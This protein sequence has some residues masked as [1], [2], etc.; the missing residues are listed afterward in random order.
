MVTSSPVCIHG[1]VTQHTTI[2]KV[3]RTRAGPHRLFLAVPRLSPRSFFSFARRIALFRSSPTTENLEQAKMRLIQRKKKMGNF[4]KQKRLYWG[5][6][7]PSKN[8]A[9]STDTPSKSSAFTNQESGKERLQT[10]KYRFAEPEGFVSP[11]LKSFN[12][13]PR[14]LGVGRSE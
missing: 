1:Q 4:W 12:Q 14:C 9:N 6:C 11:P 13:K 3:S 2:Q 7:A 5:T 10:M 8:T